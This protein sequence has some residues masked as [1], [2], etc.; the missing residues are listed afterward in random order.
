M[1]CYYLNSAQYIWHESNMHRRLFKPHFPLPLLMNN[2]VSLTVHMPIGSSRCPDVQMTTPCRC[3]DDRPVRVSRRSHI[4]YTT[5]TAEGA[6]WRWWLAMCQ[7]GMIW[8]PRSAAGV[9]ERS[10]AHSQHTT[11]HGEELDGKT[12]VMCI[13]KTQCF[14]RQVADEVRCYRNG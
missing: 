7:G 5:Q 2:S 12:K 14:D 6:S 11:R 8:P 10:L 4:W 9:L 1:H 3:L 13:V